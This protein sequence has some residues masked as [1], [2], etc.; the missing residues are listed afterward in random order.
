MKQEV[1][2]AIQE[3]RVYQNRKWGTVEQRPHEV[4]AW[5]TIMRSLLSRAETAWASSKGDTG[6]LDE[7]RK[8]AA[9]AIA[10]MEQHGPVERNRFDFVEQSGNFTVHR[11][12]NED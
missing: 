8:V 3:E 6:A 9:V 5:I 2:N 10:C 12:K 7:I 1:L 4:G 11:G